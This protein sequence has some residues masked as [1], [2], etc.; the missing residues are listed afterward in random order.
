MKWEEKFYSGNI[1]SFVYRSRKY[2][3][4][5]RIIHECVN[6]HVES[7]FPISYLHCAVNYSAPS[8]N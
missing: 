7:A 4:L 5:T 2:E 8:E 3:I 6:F 1:V